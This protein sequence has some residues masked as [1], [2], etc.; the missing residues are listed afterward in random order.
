MFEKFVKSFRIA[1]RFVQ[2]NAKYCGSSARCHLVAFIEIGE[3]EIFSISGCI[4]WWS[5]TSCRR[6][7][8]QSAL[9]DKLCSTRLAR[10]RQ[11]LWKICV[12]LGVL[13]ELQ[14]FFL[15][16]LWQ[17]AFNTCFVHEMLTGISSATTHFILFLLE[18]NLPRFG[19]T[20]QNGQAAS[21]PF[22]QQDVPAE[23][24]VPKHCRHPG[25]LSPWLSD[26]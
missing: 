2:W 1:G 19:L 5:R 17:S 21:H 23:R 18:I 26:F 25:I 8:G 4:R 13:Y 16:A 14:V 12:E 11:N 24:F 10:S 7:L 3:I 22:V 6:Y 20:W 15:C 9:S